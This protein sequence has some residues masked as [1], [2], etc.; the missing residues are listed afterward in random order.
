M[1]TNSSNTYLSPAASQIF[2]LLTTIPRGK[3]TTYGELARAVG[4]H[5]R[6]VGRIL[7]QN[8]DPDTFPCHRVVKSDGSVAGGYAFGGPHI[9]RSVLE[10]EG[11]QFVRDKIDLKLFGWMV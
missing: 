9:Q 4:I 11:V 7:H 5:P 3:V 6:Q 10:S 2:H 8:T 1:S